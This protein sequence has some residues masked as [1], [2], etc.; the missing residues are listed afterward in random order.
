MRTSDLP[1]CTAVSMIGEKLLL[2]I[3]QRRPGDKDILRDMAQAYYDV[4]MYDKAFEFCQQLL[5]ADKND[6]KALYQAGM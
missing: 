3:Y 6:A 2:E 4:K 1:A 5:E